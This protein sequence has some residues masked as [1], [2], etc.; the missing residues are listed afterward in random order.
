MDTAWIYASL[1]A[2]SGLIIA[3][4]RTLQSLYTQLASRFVV[5]LLL[6]G[7]CTNAMEAYC[8]DRLQTS[9]FGLRRY[10]GWLFYVI[11]A[12]RIQPCVVEKMS[13]GG[14]L[15]WDGWKPLWVVYNR[16]TGNG[17][18][19]MADA[20]V[21]VRFVRGLFEADTLMLAINEHYMHRGEQHD[22]TRQ[23]QRKRY[24]VTHRFGSVGR[25]FNA[26]AS[27]DAPTSVTNTGGHVPSERVSRLLQYTWDDIGDPTHEGD[28][29][30]HMALS[31]AMLSAVTEMQ[32][33]RDSEDWYRSHDVPWKWGALFHGGPGTGKTSFARAIGEYLDLP[34][35]VYDL[36]SMLNEEL[37]R[38]WD[39]M[40]EQVP[41]IALVEDIDTQFNGRETIK[42]KLSFD[43][44]LN[45]IDGIVRAEGLLMIITTNKLE[46]VDP[47]LG[48]PNQAGVSTRPGRLDRLIEFVNPDPAGRLKI[49]QRI[50]QEWPDL[51]DEAVVAGDCETGAQFQ[52]RCRQI[53][54]ELHCR[55][56]P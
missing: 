18:L 19:V 21:T 55:L 51:W 20:H 36:S 7:H 28:A 29:L 31:P 52:D 40:L 41:C 5:T 14:R 26:N 8:W 17:A 13:P 35:Y 44:F 42:G 22:S 37:R 15:Y 38:H 6:E 24:N 39:A 2:A 11:P 53:A 50:L 34:V 43:S 46:L 23:R 3:S 4:W 45:C 9:R 27:G 30:D 16:Q 49:C 1:A 10:E 32:H 47:A 54:I 48:V 56:Q 12:Q 25:P 33:W